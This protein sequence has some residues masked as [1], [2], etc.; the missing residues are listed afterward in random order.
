M[1]PR[2]PRHAASNLPSPRAPHLATR[3]SSLPCNVDAVRVVPI[4]GQEF[5]PLSSG[6]LED[7]EGLEGQLHESQALVGGEVVAFQE[8]EADLHPGYRVDCG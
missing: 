8:A 2:G 5:D 7:L 1:R 4:H 3:S 6:V